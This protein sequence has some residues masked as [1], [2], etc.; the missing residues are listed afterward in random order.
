MNTRSRTLLAGTLLAFS[1]MGIGLMPYS[2]SQI[3]S[4][5]TVWAA[6]GIFPGAGSGGLALSDVNNAETNLTTATV[7]ARDGEDVGIVHALTRG[8]DGKIKTV[9][10]QISSSPSMRGGIVIL[11]AHSLIYLSDDN[12]IQTS[13]TQHQVAN[14]PRVDG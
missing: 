12:V 5:H 6:A 8:A 3:G 7:K 4:V 2:P 10:V 13:L 1:S 9:Q 11:D 14:M